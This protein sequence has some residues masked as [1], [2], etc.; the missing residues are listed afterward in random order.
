MFDCPPLS[1][2]TGAAPEWFAG[3]GTLVLAVAAIFQQWFHQLLV[4]PRLNLNARVAHPVAEKTR[5]KYGTDA[6]YFRLGI[7][8]DGN[9]AAQD[10]QVYLASVEKLRQDNSYEIVDR[11]SPTNLLWAHA[12][13][14]TKPV[15]VP[16]MPP[17]FL[18]LGLHFRPREANQ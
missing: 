16:K 7:T 1:F 2:W 4:R 8:N 13:S 5:W 10:V 17:A 12:G 14:S 3:I 6:Y 18:R 11:F 9:A 15:L